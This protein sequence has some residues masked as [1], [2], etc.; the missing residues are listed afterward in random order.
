MHRAPMRPHG[1]GASRPGLQR[2]IERANVAAGATLLPRRRHTWYPGAVVPS[3]TLRLYAYAG[4]RDGTLPREPRQCRP[5]G[6]R[7]L[8]T[9]QLVMPLAFDD[10]EER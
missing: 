6:L 10:N 5:K 9:E 3:R 8:Q 7:G 2:F 4:V 1:S